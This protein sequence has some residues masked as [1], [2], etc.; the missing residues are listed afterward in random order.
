MSLFDNVKRTLGDAASTAIDVG[1]TLSAQAQAQLAIKKLQ[2]EHAKKLHEL[3]ARTHEWHRAGNLIAAGPVPRE[4]QDV[5]LQ[6]DD[7]SR[8]LDDQSL[9]LEEAKRQVELRSETRLIN[10]T[11]TAPEMSESEDVA[12]ATQSAATQSATTQST[13]PQSGNATQVLSPPIDVEPIVIAE[14]GADSSTRS[15]DEA[16]GLDVPTTYVN[17]TAGNNAPPASLSE[18][19]NPTPSTRPGM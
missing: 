17:D 9:K 8:Q 11:I 4:V 14:P 18:P 13:S 12:L 3:G 19:I 16:G 15:A 5:C 10:R 1:Q 7:L 6:L 2:V